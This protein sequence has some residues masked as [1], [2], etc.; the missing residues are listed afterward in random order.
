MRTFPFVCVPRTTGSAA[1]SDAEL[2]SRRAALLAQLH[3]HE[4]DW[5]RVTHVHIFNRY[6][7]RRMHCPRSP[8][9]PLPAT[10]YCIPASPRAS[11]LDTPSPS[12]SPNI[13]PLP[14]L[15]PHM[16]VAT[17]DLPPSPKLDPI[18]SPHIE[19]SYKKFTV[20]PP[21]PPEVDF[22]KHYKYPPTTSTITEADIIKKK[23][24]TQCQLPQLSPPSTSE[25]CI[26]QPLISPLS[27]TASENSN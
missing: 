26:K 23:Y 14:H 13:L 5:R 16:S 12:T 25:D 2:E 10:D 22:V 18:L 17:D 6:P 11:P 1:W 4:A 7:A 3:E 15:S 27:N 8:H 19:Y 24:E 21:S 9:S 20:R